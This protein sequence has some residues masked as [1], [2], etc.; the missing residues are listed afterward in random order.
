ME[1]NEA[2]DVALHARYALGSKSLGREPKT[3]ITEPRGLKMRMDR[4]MGKFKGNRKEAAAAAGVPYSTWNHLLAGRRVSVKNL[5]RITEAFGRLVTLP[6]RKLRVK[7]R[8]LPD[9]WSI[10]AVVVVHP[11]GSRYINGYPP[12]TPP[13]DIWH[14]T[15]PPAYRTFNA[16]GLHSQTIVDAWLTGGAD[17]A[18]AALVD[19]VEAVYGDPIGFEGANVDVAFHH[20]P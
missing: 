6:A 20:R 7:R 9:I 12:G 5:A 16:E 8:G 13:E 19:E 15:R 1:L 18:G 4:I 14:V 17:G 10:R 11:D 2:V 3:P